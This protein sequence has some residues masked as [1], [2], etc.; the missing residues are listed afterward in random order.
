MDPMKDSDERRVS[1][2]VGF[3]STNYRHIFRIPSDLEAEAK[4]RIDALKAKQAE[5]PKVTCYCQQV[6]KEE[7]MLQKEVSSRQ[8]LAN[9]L[10]IIINDENM[11]ARMRKKRLKQVWLASLDTLALQ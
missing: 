5:H 2:L 1:Q 9:L 3:M 6:T 7:Y 10:E 11:T 4:G 8:H